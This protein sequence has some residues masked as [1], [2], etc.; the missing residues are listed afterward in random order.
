VARPT[1]TPARIDDPDIS[2][3]A[4]LYRVLYEENWSHVEDGI[5]RVSSHAFKDTL[6]FEASCFLA[7]EKSVSELQ[8]MFPGKRIC[9][10]SAAA[11]REASHILARAPEDCDGDRSHVVLCPPGGLNRSEADKLYARIARASTI[12]ES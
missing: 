12:V 4:V 10:V 11:V 8:Q 5:R 7:S 2:N 3:E 9:Q 1:P 6:T